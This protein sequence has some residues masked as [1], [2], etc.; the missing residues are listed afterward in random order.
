MAAAA[1]TRASAS[2]SPSAFALLV[3]Q[4][5]PATRAISASVFPAA[6]P[7]ATISAICLRIFAGLCRGAPAL[8]L[9][10]YTLFKARGVSAFRVDTAGPIIQSGVTTSLDS[11]YVTINRL[12]TQDFVG[13]SL[14]QALDKFCKEPKT[15]SLKSAVL[16]ESQAF[17][18]GLVQQ[19]LI[20][21]GYVDGQSADT[22]E[23]SE[24]GVLPL[25]VYVK[26][27]PTADFI[28]LRM[29]VGTTVDIVRG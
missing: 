15:A 9:T 7:F 11:R 12:R 14:A 19:E 8:D 4:A 16:L 3:S 29:R 23:F 21:D 13:L 5:S 18:D 27:T 20:T 25:L 6:C 26:T 2:A 24:A 22:K 28:L 10:T 17:L 1:C